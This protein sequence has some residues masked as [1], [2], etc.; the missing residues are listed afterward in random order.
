MCFLCERE[1]VG[2]SLLMQLEIAAKTFF[3][4]F[5]YLK[6]LIDSSAIQGFLRERKVISGQNAE[7]RLFELAQV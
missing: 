7:A 1:A 2:G 3:F 6:M 5:F 4:S